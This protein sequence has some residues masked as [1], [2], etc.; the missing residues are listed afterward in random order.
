MKNAN[1]ETIAGFCIKQ[2]LDNISEKYW[3]DK[4]GENSR[5]WFRKKESNN[6]LKMTKNWNKLHKPKQQI[7]KS[8]C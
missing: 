2:K 7:H 6:I 1:M 8:E 5:I 4:K 3:K